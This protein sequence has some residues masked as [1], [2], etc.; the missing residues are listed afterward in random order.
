MPAKILIGADFVPTESN[1]EYFKNG[2]VQTLVGNDLLKALNESDF[3]I[4]NL[5]VPLTD[6]KDPIAKCGPNLIA[7]THTIN[8]LKAINPHFFTLANNHILD[9]GQQGLTSTLKVLSSAGIDYAGAG[10]NLKE[11]KKPYIV[12]ING[13]KIGIYCCTEHEFT[14]ATAES[15]GANPFDP[16]E[17]FDHVTK[18]KEVTDYVIV[19][20]HGGKEHYRYPSPNL[21][22]ICRKFVDKGANL[23]V[24]QH[25]HCI[26]AQE[27]WKGGNI[28]YG[29]GNFLFDRSDSECWQSS[30]LIE[31]TLTR[32]LDGITS[33]F[34]YLPLEKK[35]NKVRF[36]K[37][38]NAEKILLD[39]NKRSEEITNINEV[40]SKYKKF[41]QEM[42]TDYLI[43]FSGSKKRDL[44]FRVLNKVSNYHYS[45]WL[46]KCRYGKKERII[47]QNFI[48]CEAHRELLL[49]G[50]KDANDE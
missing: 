47:L 49:T 22:K 14:I 2:D 21:Q 29:Q 31:V 38:E 23:I 3:S 37:N 16:L 24:C 48:E 46:M 19:L 35:E 18:L 25:S 8:G 4:F 27:E 11:A 7:P 6:K 12:T 26:G 34:V 45:K 39:F 50:L 28:I 1:Y 5:E 13:I 36:A 43:G 17:S 15:A 9:Q 32:T 41:S 42:L 44:I 20:Y 30:L 33:N 10:E 40:C